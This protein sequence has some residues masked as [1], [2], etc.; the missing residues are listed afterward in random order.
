MFL[1]DRLVA[2]SSR[3]LAVMIGVARS[4]KGRGW[5][6]VRGRPEVFSP[7]SLPSCSSPQSSTLN[8]S[9]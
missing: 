3:S 9:E 2:R 1:M 6:R 7:H 8:Q 4:A 5:E